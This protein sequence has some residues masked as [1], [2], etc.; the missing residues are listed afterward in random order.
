MT[1]PARKA[2]GGAPAD[3]RGALL[4]VDAVEGETARLL[5]QEGPAFEVPARLLPAGAVEGSWVRI[6]LAL[7]PPPPDRGSNL[8]RRLGAGDD[9]G[10]I[11]L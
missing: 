7:A 5:L 11:K 2:K 6:S 4:F 8:R 10:D 1:L 9:G 3:P